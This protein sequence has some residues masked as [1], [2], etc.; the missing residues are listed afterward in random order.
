MNSGA[1]P[2][3]WLAGIDQL[4]KSLGR[5]NLTPLNLCRPQL[6]NTRPARVETGGFG[7]ESDSVERDQR[8]GPLLILATMLAP[9]GNFDKTTGGIR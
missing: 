7:I 6:Y 5:I 3:D 1:L 9:P 4:L 2:W 8:Y